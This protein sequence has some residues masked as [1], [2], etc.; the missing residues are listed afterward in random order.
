[1]IGSPLG[2]LS[3]LAVAL[4]TDAWIFLDSRKRRA[5]GRVVVATI[6]PVN[7]ST[8]EQW[9]LGGLVLWI[10]VVPLYLVARRA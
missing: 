3:L 9:L 8:P 1:M 4:A 7:L 5:S 2:P 6:G 10:V